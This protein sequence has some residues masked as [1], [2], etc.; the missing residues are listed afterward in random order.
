MDY[1]T[2]GIFAH[3]NAGKTTVTENIL[4]ETGI[5]SR[6]GRVDNGTTI[7]DSM[8]TERLRGITIRS[9]YVTFRLKNRNVQLLDTPGHI[10]FSAEVVR[11]MRVLDAAIFVISGVEG[12]EAQTYYIWN[13]LKKMNVPIIFFVNK[14]DRMGADYNRTV[15]EL[16]AAFSE[17]I[18]SLQDIKLSDDNIFISRKRNVEIVDQI[19]LFDE[20]TLNK[21]LENEDSVTNSW[22]EERIK[23]LYKL[24]QIYCV[25]GGS[26]LLQGGVKE[27]LDCIGKYLP[28]FQF[29][30][31]KKFSGIV[32]MNKRNNNIK[33]TYIKVLQGKLKNREELKIGDEIQKIKSM[34]CINGDNRELCGSS[35]A[36]QLVV[37]TGVDVA[38]G[39]IIGEDIKRDLAEISL[40]PMFRATLSVYKETEKNVLW[41]A[42]KELNEEDPLLHA[43]IELD[44]GNIQVDLMGKLQGET[45]VQLLAEKYHLEVKL[46][47]PTI[48]YKETPIN[49]GIG[50]ASYTKTSNVALKIIPL[51]RGKGVRFKSLLA[52][53]YLFAK[54]QKQIEKLLYKYINSGLYGW[55]VTD[56]E[57]QLIGGKC[58]NVGS[59]TKDYNIATPIAFMRALKECGTNLLEP[60]VMYTIS[61]PQGF[62][63][64]IIKKLAGTKKGYEEIHLNSKDEYIIRGK[65]Y[66]T[67]IIEFVDSLREITSGKGVVNYIH[68]GY[69]EALLIEPIEQVRIDVT[70][71]NETKFVLGMNG[72]IENLDKGLE[73]K[74][75]KPE[76]IKRNKH[77]WKRNK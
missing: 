62:S 11:A 29:V 73:T 67:E 36:G 35:E 19:T 1:C 55:E 20:I 28:Q 37:V 38:P 74:R 31:N 8:E 12:I 10:D 60:I 3:A 2:I 70:P 6:I 27:L 42:I 47:E 59:E 34:F 63:V 50:K 56:C 41:G 44:S 23:K 71:K 7:T 18:V 24:N 64:E 77:L 13:M 72:S 22:L 9:S 58:D 14:L 51:E 46:S 53:D 25:T 45:L 52:T 17:R 65:A 30:R 21:Y 33:E 40:F 54:Y 26:A 16:K 32:Y 39:Q 68:A 15:N 48:I 76:K 57:I 4:Y 5:I 66:L 69:E 61:V 75:G 43:R 49:E